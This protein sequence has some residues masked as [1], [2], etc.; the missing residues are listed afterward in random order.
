MV[1]CVSGTSL[2]PGG[3]A[4]QM[5]CAD[6]RRQPPK[7]QHPF[8]AIAQRVLHWHGGR[9]GNR[10]TEADQHSVEAHHQANVA[11][12]VALDDYGR[13]HAQETHRRPDDHSADKK[14][15][16]T[17]TAHH[18]PDRQRQKR[19][20]QHGFGAE[21]A[22]KRRCD[23]PERAKT[24]HRRHGQNADFEPRETKVA[25][26]VGEEQRHG[27]DGRPQIKCDQQHGCDGPAWVPSQLRP[28]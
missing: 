12:K 7:Q 1:T 5:R 11:G 28:D 14:R 21:A 18:A 2:V 8:P 6:P 19:R 10:R 3:T 25:P 16:C 20:L 4:A 22:G 23:R 24:D 26:D 15:R 13:Q 27:R 9:C 17:E